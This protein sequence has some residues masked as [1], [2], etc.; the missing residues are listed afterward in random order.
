MEFTWKIGYGEG[1]PS[2]SKSLN[3]MFNIG[4]ETYTIRKNANRWVAYIAAILE[5]TILSTC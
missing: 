3:V 5:N 2:R 1:R 4:N